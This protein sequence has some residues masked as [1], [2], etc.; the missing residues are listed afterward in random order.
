MMVKSRY[1]MPTADDLGEVTWRKS[2]R[3]NSTGNC[4]QFTEIDGGRRVAVRDSKDPHGPALLFGRADITVLL[5]GL[6]AG[7][8]DHLLAAVTG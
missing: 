3:S 5:T 7:S 2:R 4:V 8:H 1:A 6:K